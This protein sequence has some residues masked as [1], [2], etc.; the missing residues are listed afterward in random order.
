MYAN[1]SICHHVR[2]A[3]GGVRH[4]YNNYWSIYGTN[5]ST[6]TGMH[7]SKGSTVTTSYVNW[8]EYISCVP[9]WPNPICTPIQLPEPI[10]L[11]YKATTNNPNQINF[12]S[13]YEYYGMPPYTYIGTGPPPVQFGGVWHLGRSGERAGEPGRYAGVESAIRGFRPCDRCQRGASVSSHGAAHQ[14]PSGGRACD[15]NCRGAGGHERSGRL[16]DLSASSL[17]GIPSARFFET[18]PVCWDCT[19]GRSRTRPWKARKPK[20]MS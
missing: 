7:C 4:L 10:T 20:I 16:P 2:S 5:L 17:E 3:D 11:T 18:T 1:N 6:C 8:F 14:N 13:L 19:S 15:S 9:G 12:Y